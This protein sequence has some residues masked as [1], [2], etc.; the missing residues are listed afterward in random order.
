M[1]IWYIK[2][3][4]ITAET[5][6]AIWLWEFLYSYIWILFKIYY[7]LEGIPI[8]LSN[9][10]LIRGYRIT[11]LVARGVLHILRG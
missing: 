3:Y 1:I 11:I 6:V 7:I 4:I 10:L 5:P 9:I 2:F 8:A